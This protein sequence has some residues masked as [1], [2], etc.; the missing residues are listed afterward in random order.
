MACS[1]GRGFTKPAAAAAVT[2][3]QQLL[4]GLMPV[5]HGHGM[6]H[7]MQQRTCS[8]KLASSTI[9]RSTAGKRRW[10]GMYSV[11]MGDRNWAW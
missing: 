6:P 9:L 5:Q 4:G 10:V 2:L 8:R 3:W 11:S 7:E 1:T